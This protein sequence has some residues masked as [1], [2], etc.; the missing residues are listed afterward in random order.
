MRERGKKETD[1]KQPLKSQVET[2]RQKLILNGH[3]T[4]IEK[5]AVRQVD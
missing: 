1:T 5:E 3:R 2:V 4:E